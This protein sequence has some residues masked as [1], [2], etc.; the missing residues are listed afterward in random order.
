[1]LVIQVAGKS[2]QTKLTT[3][4]GTDSIQ[5]NKEKKVFLF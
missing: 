5:T 3:S 2:A 1:M 4:G